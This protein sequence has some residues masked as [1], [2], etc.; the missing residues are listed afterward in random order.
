MTKK[1][2]TQ[3]IICILAFGFNHLQ[4]QV[5]ETNPFEGARGF[6]IF[7]EDSMVVHGKENK[8]SLACGGNF[9]M[10]TDKGYKTG[11]N[12]I[13]S[14]VANSDAEIT[15][16]YIGGMLR[17]PAGGEL[18]IEKDAYVKIRSLGTLN[19]QIDGN[20]TELFD[21]SEK[22][23]SAKASQN[24]SNITQMGDLNIPQ[25]FSTMRILSG[26]LS[27]RTDNVS[28][29]ASGFVDCSQNRYNYLT[30]TPAQIDSNWKITTNA[31]ANHF[32]CINV[33]GNNTPLHLV[34]GKFDTKS[35]PEYSMMN[36]TNVPALYF[37][38]MKSNF[39]FSL[40]APNTHGYFD[41]KK[42]E[43][44]LVFKNYNQS[45]K[46]YHKPG[47]FKGSFDCNEGGP[48]PLKLVSFTGYIN[49][50]NPVI[51]WNTTNETGVSQ[52]GIERGNDGT[53]F[54]EI[55]TTA[56]LRNSTSNT[57]RYI[58]P[59]AESGTNYYRLKI[60]DDNGSFSYSHTLS[61]NALMKGITV[62]S[63]SPN[64]FRE[65]IRLDITSEK[66]EQLTIRIID[67]MGRMVYRK[68]A[69]IIPGNNKIN[70]R[71]LSALSNGI[72]FLDLRT[73]NFNHQ[74]KVMK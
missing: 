21:G 32:L 34:N 23:L 49:A 3:L 16:T 53:N 57:Y 74:I 47:L 61:L 56:S 7:I 55:G 27:S 39:E 68:S 19:C 5:N 60:Y 63:I 25:A 31:D 9:I 46:I 62:N 37:D 66:A 73:E 20:K 35:D 26:C 45:D 28:F 36:F 22:V 14:Y 67:N 18:K 8:G 71:R 43:G 29:D 65:I 24:C 52:Y 2:F 54:R 38:D 64:P 59:R 10:M 17:S 51:E 69:K 70:L 15:S 33:R 12:S 72:Y 50:G 41:D 42:Q 48:L 11:S 58:D 4:A 30:L 6:G 44:Q 40:F 1:I 13:G